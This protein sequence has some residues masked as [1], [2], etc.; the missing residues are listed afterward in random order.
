MG[1]IVHAH[2]VAVE[3]CHALVV[4]DSGPVLG[5]HHPIVQ[6]I[7]CSL[8]VLNVHRGVVLGAEALLGRHDLLRSLRQRRQLDHASGVSFDELFALL[9]L[10]AVCVR[11]VGLGLLSH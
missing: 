1:T 2:L 7:Q 6:V 5:L 9:S 3:A 10:H 4:L 8:H 11:N